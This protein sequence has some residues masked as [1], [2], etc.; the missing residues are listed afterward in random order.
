M[1]LSLIVGIILGAIAVIFAF[2]NVAVVT[3]TFLTWQI[4]ASLA[5]IILGTL[6]CGI[7]LTLLFLLPSVIRD[8]MYVAALKK[9]KRETEDELSRVR[10]NGVSTTTSSTTVST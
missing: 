3:V 7:V 4:T 6:L 10:N 5:I 1:L 8:E 2:Q 9:Q